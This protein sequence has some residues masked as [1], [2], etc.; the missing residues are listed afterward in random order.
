MRIISDSHHFVYL[1]G[2]RIT[3]IAKSDSLIHQHELQ[4][5]YKVNAML[6]R[7]VEKIPNGFTMEYLGEAPSIEQF[8]FMT[9]ALALKKL[10]ETPGSESLPDH[11]HWV[12][13]THQKIHD[14]VENEKLQEFLLS[15]IPK[16]IEIN[17]PLGLVLT[18]PHRG[19]WCIKNNELHPIDFETAVYGPL[20]YSIGAL[21]HAAILEE[22][23][24]NW[25][26]HE[27][28]KNLDHDLVNW[29]KT[30]KFVSAMSWL[31]SKGRLDELKRRA[32]MLSWE[33]P[34]VS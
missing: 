1:D 5:D 19:N 6:H 17:S 22:R 33:L 32:R 18:D 9:V 10:H 16:N 2:Q 27:D 30:L 7:N 3:K 11:T 28:F 12:Q 23:E 31:M 21:E 14:R 26:T 24:F 15:K 25:Q 34:D 4:R 29:A 20:E 13:E 8:D